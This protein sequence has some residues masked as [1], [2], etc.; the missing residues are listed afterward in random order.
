MQK[1]K[2]KKDKEKGAIKMEK[3]N[4]YNTKK[5]VSR[6]ALEKAVTSLP[7]GEWHSELIK[8]KDSGVEFPI[9][10]VLIP[11]KVKG[12][13]EEVI[14]Q[15]L[16][17]ECYPN[18]LCHYEMGIHYTSTTIGKGRYE[19]LQK[20]LFEF[21]QPDWYLDFDFTDDVFVE[22]KHEGLSWDDFN[23]SYRYFE[24][25]EH[26]LINQYLIIET[27][28]KENT[29]PLM[30]IIYKQMYNRKDEIYQNQFVYWNEMIYGRYMYDSREL[31]I[32]DNRL[33]YKAIYG[34]STVTRGRFIR[35]QNTNEA[36]EMLRV[37]EEGTPARFFPKELAD[38]RQHRLF[39][40]EKDSFLWTELARVSSIPTT[41]KEVGTLET[42]GFQLT[43]HSDK[44]LEENK[45]TFQPGDYVKHVKGYYGEIQEG[46][47]PETGVYRVLWEA[48]RDN[49]D[50][51]EN[52]HMSELTLVTSPKQNH[53]DELVIGEYGFV[54]KMVFEG[55]KFSVVKILILKKNSDGIK[56]YDWRNLSIE[57]KSLYLVESEE[58]KKSFKMFQLETDWRSYF[59]E[60]ALDYSWSF[61]N[62]WLNH[63]LMFDFNDFRNSDAR[64]QNLFFY[65]LTTLTRST[66]YFFE[67]QEL[68]L[69]STVNA[70]ER[71]KRTDDQD[72]EY[73]YEKANQF[74]K[75]VLNHPK[76]KFAFK[77]FQSQDESTN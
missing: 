13:K 67:V 76:F 75:L 21:L 36:Y 40:Y 54:G 65:L 27:V 8:V 72:L 26:G 34:D 25:Y 62:L 33:I 3:I 50:K 66:N 43:I 2:R 55:F 47:L 71:Y 49:L 7:K 48:S 38:L 30:D 17:A 28:A 32:E 24:N 74:F 23:R 46:S 39:E 44:L 10:R 73:S 37:W 41:Q 51:T 57:N 4:L 56:Y 63:C 61:L 5:P 45:T 69:K 22:V 53:T 77:K 20:M 18:A 14:I 9:H 68:I 31:R 12:I 29:E 70:N 64:L 6:L 19:T 58:W 35:I 15:T 59:N 1:E 60:M 42:T 16:W 52:C 11:F